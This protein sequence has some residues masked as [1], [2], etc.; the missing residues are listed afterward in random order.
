MGRDELKEVDR[1]NV[2]SSKTDVGS[3]PLI[4][5][6]VWL[7]FIGRSGAIP[8]IESVLRLALKCIK[9]DLISLILYLPPYLVWRVC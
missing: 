5:I 8:C 3:R 1:Y 7:G 9:F 2:F 6:D 4:Y